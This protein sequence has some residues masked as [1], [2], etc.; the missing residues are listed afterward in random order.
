MCLADR[1]Q[2]LTT[3]YAVEV[4]PV[5]LRAYLTTYVNMMWG[6]GQLISVGVLRAMLSRKD[7]WSY[8]IPFAL[9]WMWPVPLIV[10][11]CFAPE[12]PW[13]L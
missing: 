10:G 12:S 1:L 8:R 11:I 2:T 13:W 7:E 9:Q 4:C 6:L 5:A 3:S